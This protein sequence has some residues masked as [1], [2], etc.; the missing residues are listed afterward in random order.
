M[1]QRSIRSLVLN[2][3]L[4]ACSLGFLPAV[5]HADDLT[6]V[7]ETLEDLEKLVA[8]FD[9]E[10]S[11]LGSL[12]KIA[13]FEQSVLLQSVK[14][15][16]PAEAKTLQKV[17][18]LKTKLAIYKNFATLQSQVAETYKQQVYCLQAIDNPLLGEEGIDCPT[19]IGKDHFSDASIS[20]LVRSTQELEA[21]I[22]SNSYQL[23][24]LQKILDSLKN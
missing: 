8:E 16:T 21:E 9:Q 23:E 18:G 1:L 14:G 20:H 4:A 22:A 24:D 11:V 13:N 6:Q 17:F 2:F 12:D 19:L 5:T 10:I 3:C 15:L 7:G